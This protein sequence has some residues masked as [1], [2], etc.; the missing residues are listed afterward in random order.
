MAR[1]Q[2]AADGRARLQ[3]DQRGLEMERRRLRMDRRGLE[4]DWRR[5]RID[6]V[7]YK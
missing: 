1:Q 7:G 2:E 5:L 3:M 6:G 4:I